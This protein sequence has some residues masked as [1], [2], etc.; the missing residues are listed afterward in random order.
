MPEAEG[1]LL[2][3][4]IK[5]VLEGRKCFQIEGEAGSV[6]IQF[7]HQAKEGPPT[8]KVRLGKSVCCDC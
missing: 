4:Y 2:R 8:K 3:R 7:P 6:L 1:V 5:R